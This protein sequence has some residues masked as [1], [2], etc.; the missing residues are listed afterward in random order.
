VYEEAES[1]GRGGDA[2]SVSSRQSAVGSGQQ[3]N[4]RQLP[5]A[6]RQPEA[7]PV[8]WRRWTDV[9]ACF[10]GREP[11]RLHLDPVEYEAL[12]RD[13]ARAC[14]ALAENADPKRAAWAAGLVLLVQPWITAGSLE[15]ADGELLADVLAR[16]RIIDRELGGRDWLRPLRRVRWLTLLVLAC[17]V[18]PPL[19]VTVTY[20]G[21]LPLADTVDSAWR[22]MRHVVRATGG[23]GLWFT[24]G[25]LLVLGFVVWAV[26]AL[27]GSRR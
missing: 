10:A 7:L 25:G 22:S 23:I 2:G 26:W 5:T 9:V 19:L 15:Q 1:S 24:G 18:V 17:L 12:H 14:E 27:A 6:H 16:C 21:E 8:L 11:G 20:W 13:L 3:P 4:P